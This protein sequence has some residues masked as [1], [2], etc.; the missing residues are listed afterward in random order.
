MKSVAQKILITFGFITLITLSVI[1]VSVSADRAAYEACAANA[2]D[3]PSV[4]NHLLT[5][6]EA[7]TGKS[8]LSVG[9]VVG[10]AISGLFDIQGAFL[11]VPLFL[12]M[13]IAAA[14][15]GMAG[16]L[17]DE[18]MVRT[19]VHMSDE[20]GKITAIND[21]WRIIRD[22]VNMSFIFILLYHGIR[23]VLGLSDAGVKKIIAGIVTTAILINF[24][25]LFTKVIID[26]SN[27][28][29]LGFYNSI[30]AAG[31]TAKGDEFAGK[32][33]FGFSGAFMKPLGITG[34]FDP[35]GL[36]QATNFTFGENGN[37]VIIYLGSIVFMLITIFIFMAVSVFFIIRFV[38]FIILLIMSPVAFL[39]IALPGLDNL[40]SK[41]W[42]TL[43]G[44][45]LF[46]PLYMFYSWLVLRLMGPGGLGSSDYTLGYA[47]MNP[48]KDTISVI[49]NF[50]ILI[51]LLVTSVI[52]AKKQATSGGIIST[53]ILDKGTGYLGSAIF[54]GASMLG[55]STLGRVGQK[56][57]ENDD[58]KKR[59][60]DGGKWARLQL[61]AGNKLASSSFD[62]RNTKVM[63]LASK[64]VTGL[65]A[66]AN[67]GK[68]INT[69]GYRGYVEEKLKADAESDKARNAQFKMSDEQKNINKQKL[70]DYEASGDEAKKKKEHI[71]ALTAQIEAEENALGIPALNKKI[72][73]LTE[74]KKAT[75]EQK[76]KTDQEITNLEKQIKETILPEEQQRLKNILLEKKKVADDIENTAKEIAT[77]LVQEN[78]KYE[79]I[80]KTSDYRDIQEKIKNRTE[81]EK[82]YI[83]SEYEKLISLADDKKGNK[84]PRIN[85]IE[86]EGDRRIKA[87]ANRLEKKSGVLSGF[88]NI[89]IDKDYTKRRASV[90]RKLANAERPEANL[91]KALKEFKFIDE[92]ENEEKSKEKKDDDKKEE[93]KTTPPPSTP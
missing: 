37:M 79:E 38:A 86:R 9:G 22:L 23:M 26:A 90:I 27:V 24:S 87:Y 44:Q 69:K 55:R 4:C 25:L 50:I 5:E 45:A 65:G 60:A 7:Q 13:K 3:D 77:Q 19:V 8:N 74:T 10:G 84:N 88:P 93:S 1:P 58:L 82:F 76:K 34:A 49:I 57:S 46:G 47:L 68:A 64:D 30:S 70:K 15:L 61:L 56:I 85:A 16:L 32:Y 14:L 59:A 17:L 62:A 91:K 35:S 11:R 48:N 78:A 18:V 53:K 36:S 92:E 21:V 83:S 52:E 33:N 66:I 42:G 31:G 80:K 75:D 67:F 28:V 43:S 63:E 41:Y 89:I 40:K 54:G 6:N 51:G 12:I 20:I 71:E 72:T 29:T 2:G 73:E 39:F 81:E